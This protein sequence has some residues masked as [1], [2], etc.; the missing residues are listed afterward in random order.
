MK[1]GIMTSEITIPGTKVKF[2]AWAIVAAVG[3]VLA[4]LILA[5]KRG[6][7][8]DFN[9]EGTYTDDSAGGAW[10]LISELLDMFQGMEFPGLSDRLL[11]IVDSPVST[12]TTT[13]QDVIEDTVVY[14]DYDQSNVWS[15][16]DHP[17]FVNPAGEIEFYVGGGV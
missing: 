15:H 9:E 14:G 6:E 17:F 13:Q 11:P 5:P 7:Q 16:D 2:P 4:V 8:G 3:G 1:K 12:A 10:E